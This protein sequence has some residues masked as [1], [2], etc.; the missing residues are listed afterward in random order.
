M[1]QR[2]VSVIRS[3]NEVGPADMIVLC[4]TTTGVEYHVVVLSEIAKNPGDGKGM[5]QTYSMCT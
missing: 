5:E 1:Y 3:P 4:Q 2:L